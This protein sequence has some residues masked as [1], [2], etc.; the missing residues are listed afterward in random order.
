MVYRTVDID[1]VE[2]FHCALDRIYFKN[3]F[4]VTRCTVDAAGVG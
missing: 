2:C 1:I 3:V 4:S